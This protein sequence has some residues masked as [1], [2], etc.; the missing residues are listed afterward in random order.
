MAREWKNVKAVS[1]KKKTQVNVTSGLSS[2]KCVCLHACTAVVF[3]FYF[4]DFQLYENMQLANVFLFI[5]DIQKVIVEW[6]SK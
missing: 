2:S 1:C 6:L 3:A 5:F 4:I